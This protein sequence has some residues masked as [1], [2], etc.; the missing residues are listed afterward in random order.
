MIRTCT[1]NLVEQ[2]TEALVNTVNTVGV[3]GK[4]IALQFKRAYPAM[5]KSYE[6]ACRRGEVKL[7]QMHVWETNQLD[8]PKFIIN[9]PTKGHWKAKSRIEDIEVGLG[10]LAKVL[11]EKAISSV[12]IPPLGCGNGGLDW[13][14]VKP[15]IVHALEA[16][17]VDVCLFEPGVTP[18]LRQGAI[19]PYSNKLDHVVKGLEGLL[20]IGT[21]DA[22]AR[23]TDAEPLF[24]LPGAAAEAAAFLE[25]GP[26]TLD[27]IGQTIAF[28]EGF[29]TSYFLSR[30]IV[31]PSPGSGMWHWREAL[32]AAMCRNR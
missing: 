29:E 4:G 10:D 16:V 5:F 31:I 8:G 7:G 17:D 12:A 1:G 9:F 30:E 23:V 18:R 14:V 21:G 3:M 11:K 28:L 25:A 27:R 32:F 26:A 19:R 20:I 22:T 6:Q 15:L 24:L 13:R 2:R